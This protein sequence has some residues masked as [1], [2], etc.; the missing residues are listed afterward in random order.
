VKKNALI[1]L[2]SALKIRHFLLASKRFS[3]L[4]GVIYLGFL[5]ILG[6]LVVLGLLVVL[7]ILVLLVVLGFL[8]FLV[9][10]AKLD[11]LCIILFRFATIFRQI[12]YLCKTK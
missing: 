2:K 9:V 12:S 11:M 5:V 4:V 10:L 1:M 6:F 3:K 8:G 7:G